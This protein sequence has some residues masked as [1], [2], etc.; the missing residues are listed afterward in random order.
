MPFWSAKGSCTGAKPT[1]TILRPQAILRPACGEPPVAGVVQGRD[2]LRYLSCSLCA[3]EW[4]VPRLRCA[5]CGQEADLAY[6]HV[7]GD[8]A[9][10]ELF[11]ETYYR[12]QT[13]AGAIPRR[14]SDVHRL[15]LR[16]IDGAWK[17]TSGL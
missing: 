10:A 15:Q 16:R 8:E 11:Y 14:D 9:F 7:E 17:I 4:N 3:A 5:S 1:A 6:F 12:V 13:P 2:R